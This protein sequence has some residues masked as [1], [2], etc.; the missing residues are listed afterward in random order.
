MIPVRQIGYGKI[1][2]KCHRIPNCKL[3]YPLAYVSIRKKDPTEFD[4]FGRYLD[5]GGV[6][7]STG[8]L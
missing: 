7:K 3:G 6:P 5:I 8:S 2:K 1:K 4:P